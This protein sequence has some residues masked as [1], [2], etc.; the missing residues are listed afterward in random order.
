MPRKLWLVT[1]LRNISKQLVWILCRRKKKR[2]RKQI[3][4]LITTYM[5]VLRT[6]WQRAKLGTLF[7]RWFNKIQNKCVKQY[8]RKLRHLMQYYPIS[9]RESWK[10]MERTVVENNCLQLN[11]LIQFLDKKNHKLLLQKHPIN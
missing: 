8:R 4:I 2:W 6:R 11:L 3:S 5:E 1:K 9:L 10:K 7:T